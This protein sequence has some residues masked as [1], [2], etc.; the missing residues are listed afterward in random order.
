MIAVADTG[1]GIPGHLRGRAF[2]AFVTGDDARSSTSGSG[3]GLG[4]S[5]ARRCATLMGG[6]LWFADSPRAPFA[7]EA[8]IELPL[9]EAGAEKR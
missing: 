7:T 3:T 9:D 5:I 6:A 4:L 1:L 8:I 2:E